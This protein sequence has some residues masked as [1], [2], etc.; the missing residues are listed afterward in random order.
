MPLLMDLAALEVRAGHADEA[1]RRCE[2]ML[3]LLNRSLP[4]VHPS[5]ILHK[6]AVATLWLLGTQSHRAIT[7]VDEVL[8]GMKSAYALLYRRQETP[9]LADAMR[10]LAT[11]LEALQVPDLQRAFGLREVAEQVR[12]RCGV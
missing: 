5:L 1:T 3:E 2:E 10:T 9:A 4:S 8:E 7:L 11:S 12:Q 6:C